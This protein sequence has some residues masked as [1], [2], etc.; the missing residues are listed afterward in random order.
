MVVRI[1]WH[2]A[3]VR[4]HA[5]A[6][7][8]LLAGG[9]AVHHGPVG[10]SPSLPLQHRLEPVLAPN[11][12]GRR[13]RMPRR[14][15]ADFH[16]RLVAVKK[17]PSMRNLS[18]RATFCSCQGNLEEQSDRSA[19]QKA[20]PAR[21]RGAG[22]VFRFRRQVAVW[23]PVASSAAERDTARYG[24]AGLPVKYRRFP[25]PSCSHGR[26]YRAAIRRHCARTASDHRRTAP[27]RL[28]RSPEDPPP[29]RT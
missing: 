20:P 9:R 3:H 17:V 1:P 15:R 8:R 28:P 5:G 14:V 23:L 22:G 16:R 11:A 2:A 26:G 27:A 7:V 18:Q 25:K 19:R 24:R 6:G 29:W 4:R 10:Q 13:R 12:G 21:I